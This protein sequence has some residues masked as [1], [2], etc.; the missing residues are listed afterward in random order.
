MTVSAVVATAAVA[1]VSLRRWRGTRA[2]RRMPCGVGALDLIGNT[3][4]V[5]LRCLSEATGCTVLAKVE[6]LNP[7]GSSKDR[8]A[9]AIIREAEATGA[10]APGGTVVEATAGS[11]GVSMALVCAARGYRC[12]LVAPDDTSEEKVA[13]IRALGATIELVRPAAIADANHA[14]NVAR[15]RAAALGSGSIFADQFENEANWRAH[16]EGTAAEIWAQTSGEVD[17]FVMG[18]G[19][20]GTLAGVSRHLKAKKPGV[21]IFLADP[22]GSALYHRVEHGALWQ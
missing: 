15:R 6:F 21:K 2:R 22:P 19:T 9:A 17:A 13:L 3:P 14:V 10:L 7:G 11:T 5:E 20:G 8:V 16:A 4:M 1:L 12:W 18:A